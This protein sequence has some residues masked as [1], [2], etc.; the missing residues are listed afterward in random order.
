MIIHKNKIIFIHIPKTAGFS[1]EKFLYGR[2]LDSSFFYEDIVYGLKD[3]KYTQHLEYSSIKNYYKGK[4]NIEKYFKFTF[5]R[6]T[7]D[8]LLSAYSYLNP[9]PNK[10]SFCN[11]L[12]KKCKNLYRMSECDHYNNQIRYIFNNNQKFL[13]FIGLFENIQ[14]DFKNLCNKINIEYKPLPIINSSKRK[15]YKEYYDEETINIVKETY[16]EEI[17]YFD[18]KF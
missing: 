2:E 4:E 14:E 11:Y 5:V 15:D 8:R 7:W 13:D 17:E 3:G 9:N 10:E 1:I 18:F 16:K 12:K 6:N